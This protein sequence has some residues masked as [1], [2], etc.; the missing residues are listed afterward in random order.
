VNLA[1]LKKGGKT[2]MKN[3]EYFYFILL[4]LVQAC[5]TGGPVGAEE[6]KVYIH[7]SFELCLKLYP[8]AD[9]ILNPMVPRISAER[10]KVLYDTGGAIFVAAGEN[11][12]RAKL[13]GA[14]PLTHTLERD[15]SGLKKFRGKFIILFCS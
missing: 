5:L 6:K 1:N 7:P 13:P 2:S 10:A 9:E 12:V 15:L 8:R 4:F 11:A 3:R 14:I